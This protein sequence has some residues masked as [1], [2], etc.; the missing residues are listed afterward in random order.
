[1][2]FSKSL[3]GGKS[4]IQFVIFKPLSYYFEE[5]KGFD[6]KASFASHPVS[7]LIR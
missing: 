5:T 2:C 7:Y 3:Q 6:V 1:M 4:A